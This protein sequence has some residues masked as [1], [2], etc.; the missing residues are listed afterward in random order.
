[1]HWFSW[2]RLSLPKRE[3]GLGFKDLKNFNLA[4]LGK[5]AWRIL[6]QPHCL[7]SRMLK[8][9]YFPDTNIMDANQ[10]QKDSFI[11]KSIL[12]GMD[13][14]KK[15]LR[16]CVGN[17]TLV[18]AWLDPCC[19]FTRRDRHKKTRDALDQHMVSELLNSTRTYW[20]FIKL[21]T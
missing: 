2:N 17:G 3:G 8:G 1:M 19:P 15:G 11:W 21:A 20:D 6:E 14:L 4:L 18:N 5:Q 12:Q 16:Y 10:G 9:R 13:L 7:M